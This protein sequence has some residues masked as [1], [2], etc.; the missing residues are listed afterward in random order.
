MGCGPSRPPPYSTP[1]KYLNK[2]QLAWALAVLAQPPSDIVTWTMAYSVAS[3]GI[4]FAHRR[5]PRN[6]QTAY[7]HAGEVALAATA[8]LAELTAG[9]I[10][11]LDVFVRDL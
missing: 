10:V 11:T 6:V 7:R 4:A 1:V 2:R 3:V 8:D 9:T 5:A